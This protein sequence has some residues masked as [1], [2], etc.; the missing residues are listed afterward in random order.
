[1][2]RD[3]IAIRRVAQA[4]KDADPAWYRIHRRASIHLT[5]LLLRAGVRPNQVSVAMMAI[6]AAGAALMALPSGTANAAGF[7]LVYLAF[8]LDKVDGEVAR[9]RGE[10]SARGLLLDRFHHNIVEPSLFLA[11]AFHAHRA[12]DSVPVLLA[13]PLVMLLANLIDENQHVTPYIFVKRTREG[14]RFAATPPPPA[15]AAA[16]RAARWLRPLKGFRMLIVALPAIYAC[17]LLEPVLGLPLTAWYLAVSVVAL[18][19]YLAFQCWF[20]YAHQL[21]A[22][23]AAEAALLERVRR[24]A[25][26]EQGDR[27]EPRPDGDGREPRREPLPIHSSRAGTHPGPAPRAIER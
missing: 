16:L 24:E 13:G 8:L 18:T 1:M 2:T 5:L 17:Y 25:G 20:Y 7:V 14:A 27:R 3:E 15:P 23:L 10:Q 21:E 11:A 22:D 4:G 26:Y 19:A 12:T 9:V 6:G